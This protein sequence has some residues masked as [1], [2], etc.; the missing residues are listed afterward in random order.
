MRCHRHG[1]D[2]RWV[3]K[4]LARLGRLDFVPGHIDALPVDVVVGAVAEPYTGWPDE[5][6]A[7]HPLVYRPF[8]DVIDR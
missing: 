7:P 4:A 5:T 8:A 6:A 2:R 3:A 1:L